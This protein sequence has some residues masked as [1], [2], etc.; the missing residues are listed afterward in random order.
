MYRW[1][2]K[3]RSTTGYKLRSLPGSELLNPSWTRFPKTVKHPERVSLG[4]TGTSGTVVIFQR[5]T[6]SRQRPYWSS[7]ASASPHVYHDDREHRTHFPNGDG[8]TK[9]VRVGTRPPRFFVTRPLPP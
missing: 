5:S 9:N 2:R 4:N 8:E 3:L 1:C 6:F 7:G